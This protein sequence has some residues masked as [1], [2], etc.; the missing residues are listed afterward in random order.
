MPFNLIEPLD[1]PGFG[2]R[3]ALPTDPILDYTPE[4][5]L[6]ALGRNLLLVLA[7]SGGGLVSAFFAVRSLARRQPGRRFIISLLVIWPLGYLLFWGSYLTSFLWDGA[8]VF[9]PY[10][11]LPMVA[12]LTIPAAVG[13]ADLFERQRSLGLVAVAGMVILNAA[14]LGPALAEHHDRS[15]NRIAVAA[16]LDDL[17]PEPSLVFMPSLFG[18]YLQNPMSFLR[19]SYC[20]LSSSESTMTLE[21]SRMSCSG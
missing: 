11:Y 8:L 6:E 16:T 5:G 10:Y 4:R 1:R 19:N 18:A 13:L 17:G 3:R 21:V 20:R 12:M 7:W 9:G 2:P 14:I 15:D